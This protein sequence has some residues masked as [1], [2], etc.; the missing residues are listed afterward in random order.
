M[1][2]SKIDSWMAFYGDKFF[3]SVK[4]YSHDIGFKYLLAI[5]WY[6]SHNKC[7]GILNDDLL[8]RKICEC[9]VEE[10]PK[11]KSILFNGSGQFFHYENGLWHQ[12]VARQLYNEALASLN[13]KRQQTAAA[14]MASK[15][16]RK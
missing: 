3:R 13:K 15:A 4:G 10:W 9:D 6:R 1:S 8:M 5:W 12:R 7:A 16:A 11:V 14:R 2:D